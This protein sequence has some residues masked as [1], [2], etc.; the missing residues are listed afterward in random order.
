M[1]KYNNITS[2]NCEL[3]TKNEQNNR[4]IDIRRN[5][6]TPLKSMEQLR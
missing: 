2:Q 3:S 1:K 6:D 5:S 4:L